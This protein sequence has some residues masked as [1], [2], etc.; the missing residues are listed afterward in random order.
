M[1][2]EIK[3]IS[4]EEA[5]RLLTN[6][7]ANRNIVP[8]R[9]AKLTAAMRA[10]TWLDD[11]APIRISDEGKLLDGQ[12]RLSAIEASGISQKL[13]IISGLD[14]ASLLVMDTGKVRTFSDYL[15]IMGVANARNLSAATTF[16]WKYQN[17]IFSWKGDI[18]RR[19]TAVL[20]DLWDT[21]EK[22]NSTLEEG[23]GL[24]RPITR[25]VKAHPSD[26]NRNVGYLVR[27]GL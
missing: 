4:P 18:M 1:R 2:V 5:I 26:G 11:G 10:G 9:V 13:V 14:P 22:H 27:I 20:S 7:H 25:A 15:T 6:R 8:R 24:T 17:G 12:H 19:P 21:W 16:L 23:L 3:V